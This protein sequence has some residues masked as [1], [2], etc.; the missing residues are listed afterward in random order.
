MKSTA[1]VVV[2]LLAGVGCQMPPP[3]GD[4]VALA[5]GPAQKRQRPIHIVDRHGDRFEIT[6]AVHTY[7]FRKGGFQYGIGKRAFRTINQPDMLEAGQVGYPTNRHK[8]L[9]VI[10]AYIEGEARGY[11]I[12]DIVRHEIVNE[13]IGHTQAAVAY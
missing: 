9:D 8:S 4:D 11:S 10:G 1:L 12:R 2:G 5:G 7:G 6:H 13:T 3:A